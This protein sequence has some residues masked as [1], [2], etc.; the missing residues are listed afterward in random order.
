MLQLKAH[1]FLVG[2]LLMYV[3]F[4]ECWCRD[5]DTSHASSAIWSSSVLIYA[6]SNWENGEF[7][8]CLT[9][10]EEQDGTEMELNQASAASAEEVWGASEKYVLWYRTRQLGR[11]FPQSHAPLRA[12]QVCYNRRWRDHPGSWP[13]VGLSENSRINDT[14]SGHAK[15]LP[16]GDS[17]PPCELICS[18][19]STSVAHKT[20][21][22]TA[23]LPWL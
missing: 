6:L 3:T 16:L 1:S 22:N 15:H 14:F 4:R 11:G 18:L 17:W 9:L 8:Q 19:P 2:K 20:W 21:R 13:R 23:L 7:P 10:W 5:V 12:S